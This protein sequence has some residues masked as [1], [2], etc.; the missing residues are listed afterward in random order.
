MKKLITIFLIFAMTLTISN[1]CSLFKN[2]SVVKSAQKTEVKSD[3][4]VKT[5]VKDSTYVEKKGITVKETKTLSEKITYERPVSPSESGAIELTGK[6]RIDT[7]ST[8][9]GD[10]LVKLLDT[11]DSRV[12][13]SV[14]QNKYT[15]E[16]MAKVTSKNS[17]SKVVP[18]S[19]ISI[20]R[21]YGET[22]DSLDTTKLVKAGHEMQKDSAAVVSSKSA[23]EN[24]DKSSRLPW[25][26]YLFIVA[27]AIGAIWVL[28]K[29]LK[30]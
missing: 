10:T 2:R 23:T 21:T 17:A 30:R 22:K 3:V 20:E 8:M 4:K 12:S 28:I 25:Y 6:F 11:E 13:L 1:G 5:A 29:Q 24:S 15:K 7:S 9:K 19:K 14:Y 26:G 27:A 16:L 18:F